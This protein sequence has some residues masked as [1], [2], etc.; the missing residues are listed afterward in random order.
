MCGM[1]MIK[2]DLKK[3][4]LCNFYTKIQWKS[5]SPVCIPATEFMSFF[6]ATFLSEKLECLLETFG[7]GFKNE[8]EM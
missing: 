1:T 3:W 8:V 5:D 7:F 6:Q 2:D 4:S